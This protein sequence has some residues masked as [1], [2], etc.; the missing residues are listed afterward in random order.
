MAKKYEIYQEIKSDENISG[1]EYKRL[2]TVKSEQAAM[3]FVDDFDN[4]GKYGDMII[5]AKVNGHTGTYKDR[6]WVWD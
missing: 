2:T 1:V 5:Q 6:K 3:A 4:I